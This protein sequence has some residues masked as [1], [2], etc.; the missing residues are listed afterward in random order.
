MIK[1]GSIVEID[2]STGLIRDLNSNKEYK[3]ERI[4]I[5]FLQE[6]IRSLEV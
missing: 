3:A 4:S 5:A 2:L 1:N 6:I